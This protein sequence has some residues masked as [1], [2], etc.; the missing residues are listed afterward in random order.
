MR[1]KNSASYVNMFS[2]VAGKRKGHIRE[3]AKPNSCGAAKEEREE[4]EERGRASVRTLYD[5]A[6]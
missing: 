5:V 6:Y 4:E 2:L 3:E 1:E